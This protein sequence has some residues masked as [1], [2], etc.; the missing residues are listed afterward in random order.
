MRPILMT[1]IG[2]IVVA[3]TVAASAD[4][5]WHKVGEVLG[6]PGTEMPGGVYRIALP[7]TDI[8]ATLDGVD[9]KPGFAL[10]GW[11]AFQKMGDAAMVMG[12]LVLTSEEVN[13]V[14]AKLLASGVE[15]TALRNHLLRN[16]PF[17][18]YMHVYGHGDAVKLATALH[19]ALAASK[20]PLVAA[21]PAPATPPQIDLDTAAIDQILGANGT[22]NGGVYGFGIWRAEPIT[23]AGMTVPA[24]M[25][26]ALAIN[27][28]PTGNGQGGDH[29]GLRADRVGSRAGHQGAA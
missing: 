21:A 19:E 9:L 4:P 27:F 17:T 2:A 14:M 25:G 10:G 20:T 16:Q 28:Q 23:D 22:N 12:D 6:K 11:L 1:V 18:M 26:S 5:V 7:R 24:A 3:S 29:R 15:V 8:K 13:P